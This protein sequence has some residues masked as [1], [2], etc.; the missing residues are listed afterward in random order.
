M[1]PHFTETE[2]IL[3]YPAVKAAYLRYQAVHGGH[4]VGTFF[5]SF[6]RA[7]LHF[8]WF[9]GRYFFSSCTFTIGCSFRLSNA[10]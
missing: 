9:V 1:I 3:N 8:V 7:W 10:G 4:I 2:K 6:V 5:G